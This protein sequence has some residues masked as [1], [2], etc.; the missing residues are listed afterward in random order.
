MYTLSNKNGALVYDVGTGELLSKTAIITDGKYTVMR[1][2]DD[3][4]ISCSYKSDIVN[5]YK[6]S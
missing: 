1:V 4:V 5:I 3:N 6:H 2:S